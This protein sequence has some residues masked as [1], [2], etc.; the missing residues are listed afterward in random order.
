MSQPR[1]GARGRFITRLA[2]M[3]AEGRILRN[4]LLFGSR[5]EQRG[6]EVVV[7]VRTERFRRHRQLVEML[8]CEFEAKRPFLRVDRGGCNG[9]QIVSSSQPLARFDDEVADLALDGIDDEAV[10][11]THV[12]FAGTQNSDRVQVTH[13]RV[14]VCCVD[15]P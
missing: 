3:D 1:H 10:E 8:R 13:G 4:G 7:R 5:S 15:I 11:L 14:D 6:H 2:R 9:H 12:S